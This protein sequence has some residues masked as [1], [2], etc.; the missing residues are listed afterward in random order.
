MILVCPQRKL[1]EESCISLWRSLAPHK[2]SCP[3][4]LISG[5][6]FHVS[7]VLFGSRKQLDDYVMYIDMVLEEPY[8]SGLLMHDPVRSGAAPSFAGAVPGSYTPTPT[9]S[10][11]GGFGSGALSPLG[12]APQSLPAAPG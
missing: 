3:W 9:P 7:S 6:Y 11:P 5:S 4:V 8:D 1:F 10:G 2:Q 12:P